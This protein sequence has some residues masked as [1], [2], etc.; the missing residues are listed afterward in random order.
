[1]ILQKYLIGCLMLKF[2]PWRVID[3]FHD[4]DQLLIRINAVI[5]ASFWIE[6]S[7]ALVFTAIQSRDK[8]VTE[9][10]GTVAIFIKRYM[11]E[12]KQT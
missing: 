8:E 6:N 2:F 10:S 4:V 5:L 11:N 1:M 9:N 3:S 7:L 12:S